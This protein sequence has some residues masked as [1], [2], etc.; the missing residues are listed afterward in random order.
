M[1]SIKY[2]KPNVLLF[3]SFKLLPGINDISA[4]NLKTLK[5]S[6]VCLRMIEAGTIEIL[7][8]E[9]SA[10]SAIEG[11]SEKKAI[12][13]IYET[14]DILL[15][16]EWASLEA[17]KNVQRAIEKQIEQITASVREG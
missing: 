8:E 10:A 13:A 2:N 16:K 6:D 11:M 5:L 9:K 4:D 1:A 14:I 3:S 7:D 15:L 17:R 12:E